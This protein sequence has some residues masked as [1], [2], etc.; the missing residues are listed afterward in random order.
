MLE[1]LAQADL[2]QGRDAEGRWRLAALPVVAGQLN[3]TLQRAEAEQ[4]AALTAVGVATAPGDLGLNLDLQHAANASS[5]WT[6]GFSLDWVWQTAGKRRLRGEQAQAEANQ[7][8]LQLATTGWNI[9]AATLRAAYA[10]SAATDRTKAEARLADAVDQWRKVAATLV[11]LGEGT[12]LEEITAT[13]ESMQIALDRADTAQRAT[14]ARSD[15]AAALGLPAAA[16][17]DWSL[18]SWPAELPSMP[19]ANELAAR[20]TQMRPD[21]LESLAAYV[22]AEAA[23]HLQVAKQYPD[24]HLGPGFSYDQGQRKWTLGLGF[25]FPL[26]GNRAAIAQAEA[27][28]ATASARFQEVQAQ[29]LAA[30]SR[31]HAAYAGALDK[32]ARAQ[33]I[34]QEAESQ[35]QAQEALLQHGTADRLAV[36]QA[37]VEASRA[38]LLQFDARDAAWLAYFDLMDAV[39]SYL[40]PFNDFSQ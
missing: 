14:V 9:D 21:V 16:V 32:L 38:S 33:A 29:A 27:K 30:V 24:V 10:I 35:R 20:A 22:A 5:P 6:Y 36:I 7:A 26:D 3:P 4:R 18:E 13:R 17:A 11:E 8:A 39:R 19:D 2:G 37:S 12:R 1:A 28:R 25:T 40:P 15:L 34:A 31:A 23:L